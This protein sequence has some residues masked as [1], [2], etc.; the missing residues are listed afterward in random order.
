MRPDSLT[1]FERK[2]WGAFT[3]GDRLCSFCGHPCLPQDHPATSKDGKRYMHFTCWYDEVPPAR[4][5]VAISY[6]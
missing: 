4:L 5:G 6:E 3:Y 2:T 1:E